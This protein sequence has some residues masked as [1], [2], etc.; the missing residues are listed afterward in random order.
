MTSANGPYGV[1][2]GAMA[3]ETTGGKDRERMTE[4]DP[5]AQGSLGERY[6]ILR[7]LKRGL[8]IETILA[9]DTAD[10]DRH[11]VVKTTRVS[12]VSPAARMRLEHEAAV[13]RRVSGSAFRPL[14]GFGREDDLLY[15]VM[16]Y[17]PGVSLE[18][19]LTDG[20]LGIRDTLTV[21]RCVL[22]GL[23]E[24]HD[25]GV[26][27]RDVKP[28]NVIV[29]EGLPVKRATLIDF[30]LAR[31]T[32]L[33]PSIRDQPVGTARYISPE[34]A[35]LIEAD[36]DERSDLYSLGILLFECLAG[37]PPFEANTVSE[38]LRMHLTSAPSELRTLRKEVPRALDE[39]VQR[40]LRKDPRDRYQSAGG[41]L[42]DIDDLARALDRGIDDPAIVVGLHD[43]R[44]TLTEPTFVGRAEELNELEGALERAR[45]GRRS[46]AFLEAPSGEGKTRLLDELAQRGSQRGA[47]VLWGQGLD[48]AAQRPFQLFAGV[49]SSLQQL[50]E[51]EPH[52]LEAI[53]H[54]LGDARDAV[55]DVLPELSGLLGPR[56][57]EALGPEAYGETRSIAALAALLDALGSRDRPAL[58]LLDDCQWADGSTVRLLQHWAERSQVD[59]PRH[60][61]IV[62]SFRSDEVPTSHDL[63]RIRPTLEVVLR[64]LDQDSIGTLLESMAGALPDEAV[65]LTEHL[66]G[67]SPFMASAILRGL[68]ESGALLNEHGR[69]EMDPIKLDDVRSS[70]Q[71]AA[72]LVRRFRLLPETTLRLLS[73]GAVLGKEFDLS[74]VAR[75]TG[76]EDSGLISAIDEARR[77]K[78]VWGRATEG[79]YRFVH[80]KLRETL[81]EMLPHGERRRLHR[82]AARHLEADGEGHA[83]DLAYHLDAAGEPE[84]AL[85]YALKAAEQARAQHALE[86][87][88]NQYEVARR[89]ADDV[90]DDVRRAIA[91]GLGDVLMLRGRYEEAARWLSEA[92]SLTESEFDRATVE[93]KLSELAFKRGDLDASREAGEGALRRLGHRVPRR[94]FAYLVAAVREILVQALHTALP[95]L[96]C[97][98]RS[99]EGAEAERLAIR[100]YSRLAHVY[101]FR[102]GSVPTLWTHLREMNLAERYPPTPELAQAYSE[103]APVMTLLAYYSRG[104]AYAERSYEIR[105]RLDDVWGQGQSLNFWGVVLYGASRYAE[106]T[107]KCRQAKRL[108]ERTGDRWE[109]NIARVH[110]A[111]ALYR[112]GDLEAALQEAR[113]VH[114][115]GLDIGDPQASG[116]GAEIWAKATG[117]NIPEGLVRTELDRDTR[118]TQLRNEVLQTEALR[119]LAKGR[120][121]DAAQTLEEACRLAGNAGIRNEYVVAAR[122]WLAT[123]LRLQ[124]EETSPLD[125]RG[126]KTLL[127][128]ARHAARKAH[129][130]ARLYRNSL[131]HALRERALLDAMRG[132]D[133]RAR[134]WIDSSLRIAEQQG[135]RAEYT[136]SLLARGRIGV[137]RGWPGASDD[138]AAGETKLAALEISG[139]TDDRD[140]EDSE[141]TLSLIDRFATI[142]DAGRRIATALSPE[143]VY[144]E[145]RKAAVQL[146]RGERCAILRVE[147]GPDGRIDLTTVSGELETA[148]S[149]SLVRRAVDTRR[150]VT[151]SEEDEN[152]STESIE[153]KRIRSGL[154][155]PIPVRGRVAACLCV[156][157]QQVG[158][159]FG[160]AEEGIAAFVGTL[161]G[162][163][164][165]NAEGFAEVQAL[166]RTLERR[167]ADRTAELE[168]SNLAL[169]DAYERERDVVRKLQ[170]LDELKSD[171]LSTVSHELRTPLTAIGGFGQTLLAH[172]G[173]MADDTKLNLA[174]RIS[175]N[176]DELDTLIGELLDFSR[177]ER[178]HL[179]IEL[180]PCD[181]REGVDRVVSKLE[182]VLAR[183]DIG[184]D[185][186]EGTLAMADGNAC[187]RVLENLLTNAAKFSSP[188]SPIF[189]S[190]SEADEEVVLSVTDRGI[191]MPPEE[192]ERV[193]ERFYRIERGDHASRGGTGIG[194]A[195]VKEFTEAQG[196]RVWVE[197]APGRGSTFNIALR[198]AVEEFEQATTSSPAS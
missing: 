97:G 79:R 62:A 113:S 45:E 94:P 108:L 69:W 99:L 161:A 181:L 46:F 168:R 137:D 28:A 64:P 48:Q 160:E 11:V 36:L 123:A 146:L 103:H 56:T 188:G 162:A 116:L 154:A 82:E 112:L 149:E 8:G 194:L 129:R 7:S 3:E 107:E 23:Q 68:V 131:P 96:F 50:A 150:P 24:A 35:G 12:S 53:G 80:D 42:A 101:W 27:H 121:G 95:R 119:L 67:G 166:T 165:E 155:A 176:A 136:R 170:E 89:G 91:E 163:A 127:R 22:L 186:P 72:V 73:I 114:S 32:R 63:R 190:A 142:L 140:V 115:A 184:V 164:L 38:V 134:R 5:V 124:A 132:R 51:T 117:G 180:E 90:D 198:R 173:R 6:R 106:C 179:K 15:L 44:R 34:Q 177:L 14:L 182:T 128:K 143:D 31:S 174:S 57:S 52:T 9:A 141:A 21:A 148:Y 13:L 175:E 172:W 55:Y 61:M 70:R 58:L 193:F 71:A 26:L 92:A 40:L 4:V 178:G 85:P 66:A 104:T 167:V 98:R 171:F 1:P 100:L 183:Y 33:D 111:F 49:A 30:G 135:A 74:F 20:A 102:L 189:I 47:W 185:V 197:S 145:T 17:I 83:F 81:L 93:A 157:H 139:G 2:S 76:H 39:I 169:K 105:R 54:Q 37:R 133:R 151:Y 122:P 126:R 75:L 153:L 29:S 138:I 88:E 77:R 65:E 156:T 87:A 152:D 10:R 18:Q 60:T 16:P 43:R 59:D 110:L 147:E 19:R 130:I 84:R 195:I 120:P 158:A 192:V 118:D 25:N 78:I 191:G 41:A 125:P 159:L 144:A 196:G 187:G 109:L 86:L